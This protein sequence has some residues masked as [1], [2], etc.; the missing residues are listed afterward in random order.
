MRNAAALPTA[1]P[2]GGSGPEEGQ[3]ARDG[4]ANVDIDR[5]ARSSNGPGADGAP[6]CETQAGESIASDGRSGGNWISREI[7]IN[8]EQTSTGIKNCHF[9]AGTCSKFK[10]YRSRKAG[11]TSDGIRRYVGVWSHADGHLGT[12]NSSQ[13]RSATQMAYRRRSGQ[14]KRPL[15]FNNHIAAIFK[16]VISKCGLCRLRTG[17]ESSTRG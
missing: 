15:S 8:C 14:V 2:K 9:T 6:G 11:R 16:N 5:V 4:I 1:E 13:R 10:C 17:Q 7:G 12:P 3:G